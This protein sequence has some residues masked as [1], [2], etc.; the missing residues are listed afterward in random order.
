[1]WSYCWGGRA[2]PRYARDSSGTYSLRMARSAAYRQ[3]YG[4][5]QEQRILRLRTQNLEYMVLTLR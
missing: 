3:P 4:V 1:M 2:R 5:C